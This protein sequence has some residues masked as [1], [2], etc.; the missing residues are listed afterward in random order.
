MF[1]LLIQSGNRAGELIELTEEIITIGSAPGNNVEL[2]E[3]DVAPFHATLVK[4]DGD[5]VLSDQQSSAGTFVNG[6]EIDERRLRPADEICLGNVLM[7]YEST[8]AIISDGAPAGGACREFFVEPPK[9]TIS[10]RTAMVGGL[11]V[12]LVVAASVA[13]IFHFRRPVDTAKTPPTP[14]A[15]LVAALPSPPP[16]APVV[17]ATPQ[18]EAPKPPPAL[19][20]SSGPD[21]RWAIIIRNTGIMPASSEQAAARMADTQASAL[22]LGDEDSVA[23]MAATLAP[24]KPLRADEIA[25]L[26]GA[27]DEISAEIPTP[28]GKNHYDHHRYGKLS[29]L[30]D[31][32][33]G[34][35][36]GLSAPAAWWRGGLRTRAEQALG[37]LRSPTQSPSMPVAATTPSP[38]SSTP[39]PSRPPSPVTPPSPPTVAVSPEL[40]W[41]VIIRDSGILPADREEP[42]RTVA[43][44]SKAPETAVMALPISL[45]KPRAPVLLETILALV[46]AAERVTQSPWGAAKEMHDFHSYRRVTFVIHPNSGEL[47]AVLAPLTWWREGLRAKAERELASAGVSQTGSTAPSSRTTPPPGVPVSTG[48]KPPGGTPGITPNPTPPVGATPQQQVAARIKNT[49][50][51]WEDPPG[52]TKGTIEIFEDSLRGSFGL[53]GPWRATGPQT[54]SWQNHVL[55]FDASFQTFT[56]WWFNLGQKRA[57]RRLG[58]AGQSPT[59][60]VHARAGA[61]PGISGPLL[62]RLRNTV[63]SWCPPNGEKLNDRNETITFQGMTVRN[64]WQGND[65]PVRQTGP[66]TVEWGGHVLT[67][68]AGLRSF[69]GTWNANNTDRWGFL[70]NPM[71]A[72][73]P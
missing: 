17:A 58:V 46:G 16:P 60:G 73:A 20:R 24:P 43:T 8:G 63:W 9:A 48:V 30:V 54:I 39:I 36:N 2:S 35:I 27:A 5:Y 71:D 65:T 33:T 12:L 1:H 55:T 62:D 22:Q 26:V 4:D 67:F 13:G 23:V 29:L 72:P 44:N 57:G 10:T 31:A 69:R 40:R 34:L 7:R 45:L 52:T 42:T 38:G 66:L 59:S 68:D 50:W 37:A 28:D 41:A 18:P 61:L 6:V 11:A 3:A 64:T 21:L 32:G 53:Q 14:A 15:S 51:S 25:A 56:G 19:P 70:L 47:A 49:K